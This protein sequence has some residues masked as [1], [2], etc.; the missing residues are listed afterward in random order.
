M[1]EESGINAAES[2]DIHPVLYLEHGS[3]IVYQA[4]NRQPSQ[5]RLVLSTNPEANG[6]SRCTPDNVQILHA[7]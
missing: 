5:Y 1:Q 6:H 4:F 3:S 7:G 2:S